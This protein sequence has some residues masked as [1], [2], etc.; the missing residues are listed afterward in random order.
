[1]AACPD[2]ANLSKVTYAEALGPYAELLYELLYEL[3]RLMATLTIF[4]Y[5]PKYSCLRK[6]SSLAI[7]RGIPVT[8]TR[9]LCITRTSTKCFLDGIVPLAVGCPDGT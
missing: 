8:Y 3:L 7:A 4:P 1:M 5:L 6:M 2:L 9:F